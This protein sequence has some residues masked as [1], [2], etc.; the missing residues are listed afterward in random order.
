M[1]R[2]HV[3]LTSIVPG[4]A[5]GTTMGKIYFAPNSVAIIRL[6]VDS[7]ILTAR[8]SLDA[9]RCSKFPR[10]NQRP[11]A[12]QLGRM[13]S[14]GGASSKKRPYERMLLMEVDDDG[15]I[16]NECLLRPHDPA[17]AQRPKF[18]NL[19]RATH[20]VDL[21]ATEKLSEKPAGSKIQKAGEFESESDSPNV[22][23]LP[24][25]KMNWRK[26]I[27]GRFARLN[28]RGRA[29]D[30][31]VAVAAWIPEEPCSTQLDLESSGAGN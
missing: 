12:A 9:T 23:E 6:D 22:I 13:S 1:Q 15:A 3:S 24:I 31:G 8:C 7:R 28:F 20:C 25:K 30:A 26:L 4:R 27:V 2:Y 17:P 18:E 29:P 14:Q 11:L 10:E 19:N 16:R 21:D 5:V